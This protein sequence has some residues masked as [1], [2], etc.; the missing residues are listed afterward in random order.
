MDDETVQRVLKRWINVCEV[1]P[2]RLAHQ[3]YR[4]KASDVPTD[5]EVT[6]AKLPDESHGEAV[7]AEVPE[8]PEPAKS[9]RGRGRGG[10]GRRGRGRAT[11]VPAEDTD[12]GTSSLSPISECSDSAPGK[13]SG[14]GSS[15][16]SSSD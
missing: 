4:P 13:C 2:N 10:G 14:T 9:A 11:A 6:A 1:Y 5:A 8:V 3:K 7:G 16:A 12:S 15:S